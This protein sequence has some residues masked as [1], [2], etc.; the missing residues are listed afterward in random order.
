M[1]T[2]L[3]LVYENR[4]TQVYPVKG[5]KFFFK[6]ALLANMEAASEN[7]KIQ[8]QELMKLASANDKSGVKA[9]TD[10]L[11]GACGSCHKAYRGKY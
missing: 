6:E 4:Y 5:S 7:L 10:K 11:L 2:F 1:A 3:P 9:Q 8:A